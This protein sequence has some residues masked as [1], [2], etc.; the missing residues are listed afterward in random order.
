[1]LA[2]DNHDTIAAIATALGNA[3]IGI[4]RISG[5]EAFTIAQRLFS[6]DKFKQKNLIP[7]H[8][9]HGSIVDPQDNT[10]LR[11]NSAK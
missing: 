3:A 1:M 2:P 10:V 11:G 4:I 7:R 8:L 6:C 9:Y 5:P